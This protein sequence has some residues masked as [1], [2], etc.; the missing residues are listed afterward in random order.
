MTIRNKNCPLNESKCIFGCSFLDGSKF[1][2]KEL[3]KECDIY[4][5][6]KKYIEEWSGEELQ[7]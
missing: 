4:K 3:Y 5:E 7:K 1:L 6:T 2:H